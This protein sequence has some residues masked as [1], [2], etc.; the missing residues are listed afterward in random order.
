M[1]DSSAVATFTRRARCRERLTVIGGM[2]TADLVWVEDVASAA[3][4]AV[5]LGLNGVYNIASGRATR[6]VDLAHMIAALAGN[7]VAVD[8]QPAGSSGSIGFPA[9]DITKARREL[10]FTPT[11]L[12][13]GLRAFDGNADT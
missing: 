6:I 7:G 3:V 11:P 9:L 12:E 13:D 1:P 5:E 10:G 8:V 4:N 2:Q